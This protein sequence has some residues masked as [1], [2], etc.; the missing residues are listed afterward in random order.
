MSPGNDA[1]SVPPGFGWAA[2]VAGAVVG[3]PDA[4][5]VVGSAGVGDADPPVQA[6]TSSPAP[7]SRAPI[8]VRFIL[9]PPIG[10]DRPPAGGSATVGE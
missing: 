8:R 5:A 2:S 7:I 6:A 9:S 10:P 3:S 4:G 1:T